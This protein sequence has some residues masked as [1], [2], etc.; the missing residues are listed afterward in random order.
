MHVKWADRAM[1]SVLALTN[2]DR[3]RAYLR[4]RLAEGYDL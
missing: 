4:K 2:D 1:R 3:Y